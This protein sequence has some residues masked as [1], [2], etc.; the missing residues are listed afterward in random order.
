MR[1]ERSDNNWMKHKISELCIGIYD[2]PHATPKKSNSGSI[3]LGISNLSHG[4]LDLSDTEHISEQDFIKWTRRIEPQPNDIV[5]SYE[6]RLGEA[7][8]IPEGLKCCLGRRMALMRPDMAKVDPRFLLYAYL[9]PEFQETIRERTVHGST[10]DRIPLIEFP[11]Y[12]LKI[13]SL[14]EQRAIARILG[15]LD[16]KIELNRRMNETLEALARAIFKS[17]FV[18]FDPVRAKAEGREPASMDAETAAHFP[19]S[20]KETEMGRVPRG[21]QVGSIRDIAAVSSG[22]RQEKR[23]NDPNEKAIIPLYG[24]GGPMAYVDMSLF[25]EPIILTGRVGTLGKV[26]RITFPC[27][28]SDNTLILLSKRKELFEYLYFQV[29]SIDFDSLNRGSTQPLVTQKDLLR[30]EI[31][32][33]RDPII[34]K[35]HN[36][37]KLLFNLIDS[38]TL[39]SK[40]L[41]NMRD[42]LLP[43]LLSGKVRMM[44]AENTLEA[45]Q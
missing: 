38:N 31:I 17:W 39:E 2:G 41:V 11:D 5:F 12:P 28:P 24:G 21:W 23:E 36:M 4:N 22:K 27:W 6:T 10:V 3:F 43:K 32:I 16:D 8:I 1:S 20:F 18:D 30:Q 26:F 25:K 37:C 42:I 29:K 13:P 40:T 14:A 45:S 19:D 9:G 44:C 33:P 34:E 15:S 7:A 35:F